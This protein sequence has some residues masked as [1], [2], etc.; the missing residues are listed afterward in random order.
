MDGWGREEYLVKTRGNTH[1]RKIIRCCLFDRIQI[2]G[3]KKKVLLLA[4]G[5]AP[6]D[7]RACVILLSRVIR[8]RRASLYSSSWFHALKVGRDKAKWAQF[9]LSV[10]LSRKEE[11]PSFLSPLSEGGKKIRDP[12]R[13][14]K[15]ARIVTFHIEERE[16]S[17][18]LSDLG[19]IFQHS[20]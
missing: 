16:N 14:E 10:L 3:G 7:L 19:S 4:P 2:D 17:T 11:E 20:T 13:D 9:S 8:K 6:A 12:A 15:T 5:H 1:L 18:C